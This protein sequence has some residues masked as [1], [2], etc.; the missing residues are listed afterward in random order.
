VGAQIDGQIIER[1]RV[2]YDLTVTGLELLPLGYDSYAEVYRVRASDQSY[3]L[4]VKRNQLDELSLLLPGYLKDRGMDQVVAPIRSITGEL[5]C[6]LDPFSL[7]LYPFIEGRSGW[8]I[9]LTDDQWVAFGAILRRLHAIHLPPDLLERMPREAFV[10]E[11]KW[12]AVVD[13]LQAVIRTRVY[14]NPVEKQL[15]SFWIEHHDEIG[16]LVD[17]AE[18]LGRRLRENPPEFVLCHADIHTANLLIDSRG[19]LFVV[20]W[21]QPVMAPRERDLQFVTVGSFVTG[22]KSERLF[23]R[24]YGE[25]DIDPL[26]MAYYRYARVVEDLGGFAEKVFLMDTTDE[27]K[28]DCRRWFEYQFSPGGPVEAA[29]RLMARLD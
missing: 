15:A 5:Y 2:N 7:I 27:A 4:K 12:R 13:D 9:G 26:A 8:D 17:R 19:K 25:T 10:P 3:F 6:R 1:L 21:D 23:F 16:L 28:E 22:E 20:D 11:P 29:H 14:E 18:A 24:G